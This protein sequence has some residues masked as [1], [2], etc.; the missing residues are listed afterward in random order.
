M[1]NAEDKKTSAPISPPKENLQIRIPFSFEKKSLLALLDEVAE[2]KEFMLVLPTGVGLDALKKQ[3]ITY[4]PQGSHDIPLDEAWHLLV[5]FLELSAFSITP[6][7]E[8]SYLII[9]A[10]AAGG[11]AANRETL[12]LYV[13]TSAHKLPPYPERIRYVYS[14]RNL[15]VPQ[16]Q[17]R[18][19]HPLTTML[20][21]LLSPNASLLFEPSSNSIIMTDKA[22]HIGATIA[23]LQELESRGFQEQIDYV[24]LAFVA[25]QKVVQIFDSLKKASG[26]Q[27]LS[28]AAGAP[29]GSTSNFIPQ[30]A[31]IIAHESNNAVIIMGKETTVERISD[32]IRNALDQAPESGKSI[33]HSY[34]L[35]NLDAQTFAPQLQNAVATMLQ[36]GGQAA[37]SLPTQGY[38]RYLQGVIVLAEGLTEVQKPPTTEKVLL[39]GKGGMEVTGIEGIQKV[40]GNRLIIA[41]TQDDWVVV[42]K[43]IEKLD[44]RRRQVLL[45]MVVIDFIYQNHTIVQ[46]NL[47]NKVDCNSPSGVQ[48]LASHISTP[49]SV[50]GATPS[51]LAQDLLQ[52]A[53]PNPLINALNPGSLLISLNDPVTPGI[54]G[55]L[56]ILQQAITSKIQS[57]P[58]LV[59]TDNQIGSIESEEIRFVQG[60]LVTTTNGTYTIPFENISASLKIEAIPHIASDDRLRLEISFTADEFI[61]A[62]TNTRLTRQLRTTATLASGQIL[63]M[64]GLLRSDTVEHNTYTPV[65]GKV[66]LG[67]V[68]FRGENRDDTITNIVLLASPIILEPRKSAAIKKVY[69]QEKIA[70]VILYENIQE[71]PRDPI[72]NLFFQDTPIRDT[73]NDY[74]SHTSNMQDVVIP[75]SKLPVRLIAQ[76]RPIL[77][78]TKPF[79]IHELK[80]L[81]ACEDALPPRRTKPLPKGSIK[82]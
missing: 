29:G 55:L 42:K 78:D 74:F 11:G 69:A 81:L 39:E 37:Q 79:R 71:N 24:P 41:A 19:N 76:K 28:S 15:K 45:Q 66:P 59:I 27:P 67:G 40:G 80:E 53:T 23:I 22:P 18:E 75:T 46:S 54:F 13:D 9:D 50:L 30:D 36:G 63:A 16:S 58:Y 6:R 52:I 68:F 56:K 12:A 73:M 10:K 44:I 65:V 32:F 61:S 82:V 62:N 47:R 72:Y 31:R 33:L 49:L 4:E 34:D 14:L 48:F 17:E 21:Q 70:D 51:Q 77:K 38:E 60:D 35:Q 43:L 1:S 20:K 64:G 8:K 2:K 25:A 7:S 26:E 3:L 57:H 5:T